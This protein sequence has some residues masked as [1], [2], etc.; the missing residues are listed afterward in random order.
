MTRNSWPIQRF[1]YTIIPK[2]RQFLTLGSSK[3][4]GYESR[5]QAATSGFWSNETL[6]ELI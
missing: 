5:G 4:T 2:S 1:G 3:P 6:H